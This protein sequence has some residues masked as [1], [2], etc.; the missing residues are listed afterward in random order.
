MEKQTLHYAFPYSTVEVQ[1][2]IG[3][4]ILSNTKTLLEVMSHTGFE[5]FTVNDFTRTNADYTAKW[6]G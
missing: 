3:F 1:T 5:G 2:D 6:I 4:I